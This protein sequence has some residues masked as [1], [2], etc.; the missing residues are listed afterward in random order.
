MLHPRAQR[1]RRGGAPAGGG[2][3]PAAV[4]M[5]AAYRRVHESTG[6]TMAVIGGWPHVISFGGQTERTNVTSVVC[7]AFLEVAN[8][9]PRSATFGIEVLGGVDSF[10]LDKLRTA[11]ERFSALHDVVVKVNGKWLPTAAAARSIVPGLQQLLPQLAGFTSITEL[12]LAYQ[13]L[14]S[15]A[16]SLCALTGLKSLNLFH[17]GIVALPDSIDDLK[18]LTDLNVSINQLTALPDTLGALAGLTKLTAYVNKLTTLPDSISALT[19]IKTLLLRNNKFTTFPK[20]IVKLTS[21]TELD[22]SENQFTTLP[23]T[24][25]A[26]TALKVLD[27]GDN[28]LAKS[29][30]SAVGGWLSAL[31][32]MGFRVNMPDEWWADEY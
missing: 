18:E 30:S 32:W 8:A 25:A 29:L 1:Q 16:D 31:E 27:L 13:G 12:N 3:V 10:S 6:L 23:D 22:L 4:A 21:L 20:P 26:L 24:M 28:P 14:V 2:G 5:T 9:M 7:V 11:H 19:Q 17:N 15:F